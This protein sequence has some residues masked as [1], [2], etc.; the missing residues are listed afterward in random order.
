MQIFNKVEVLVKHF[1]TAIF[2]MVSLC[3]ARGKVEPTMVVNDSTYQIEYSFETSL[4]DDKIFEVLL[5]FNHVEQY[6]KK[7]VLS[8]QLIEEDSLSNK[9]N[10]HYNYLVAHLDIQMHRTADREEREVIFQQFS[11]DRSARIIPLVRHSNGYY[12]M[13]N[14]DGKTMIH[15]FQTATFDR[16]VN[17]MIKNMAYKET[18]NFLEDL[19][20]YIEEQESESP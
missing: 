20:E 4:S 12:K 7:P 19:W 17:R 13:S 3:L 15:Y 1:F 9:I 14:V 16:N 11:Y 6:L 2:I 8:I 10:Y 5:D 18:R